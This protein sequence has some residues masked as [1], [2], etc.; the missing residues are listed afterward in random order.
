VRELVWSRAT[1]IVWLNYSIFVALRRA[2]ARSVR[3]IIRRERL[4]GGNRETFRRA[5]LSHE[6]PLLWILQSH[7]RRRRQFREM[8]ASDAYKHLTLF[9]ACHPR[10]VAAIFRE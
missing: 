10:D 5:F 3:R 4:W 8:L 2:A 6:G 1:A 7:H 9:E